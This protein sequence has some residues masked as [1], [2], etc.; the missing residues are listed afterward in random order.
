MIIEEVAKE[1]SGTSFLGTLARVLVVQLGPM[2]TLT[3]VLD[4]GLGGRGTRC[5]VAARSVWADET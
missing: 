4:V 1:G 3:Q 5:A 2:G